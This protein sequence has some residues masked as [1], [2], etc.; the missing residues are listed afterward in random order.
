MSSVCS[1]MVNLDSVKQAGT[2]VH[3][4]SA[5]GQDVVTIA[6]SKQFQSIVVTSSAIKQGSTYKVYLGGSSTGTVKDTVYSGG[7]Y[8]PGTEYVSLSIEGVVTTSGQTGGFGG[9]K[10]GPGGGTRPGQ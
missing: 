3:V 4:E 1:I 9:R 6:P 7:A 2:L 10:G 5:D 8:T